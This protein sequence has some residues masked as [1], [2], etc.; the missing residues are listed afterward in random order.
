MPT[1]VGD[2]EYEAAVAAD[3][4]ERKRLQLRAQKFQAYLYGA[5]TVGGFFYVR[6]RHPLTTEMYAPI[7]HKAAPG[8]AAAIG[9]I[10]AFLILSKM[11]GRILTDVAPQRAK[12]E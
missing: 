9:C 7:L 4:A 5:I 1:E 10:V 8:V 12:Q 11:M 2:A 3:A 6:A